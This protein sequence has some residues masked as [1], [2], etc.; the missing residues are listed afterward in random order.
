MTQEDGKR[1]CGYRAAELIEDGMQV[2][3]GTGSTVY[4]FIEKLIERVKSGLNI[5]AAFSSIRSKNQAM[6]GGIPHIENDLFTKLD[7]T[8]DG[9]DEI[10]AQFNMIKGGGGA[11]LREKILATSS[12]KMIII[13]DESKEVAKLGGAKLPIEICQFAYTATIDK[14]QNLGFN[15][16]IRVDQDRFY[17]TDGGNFIFDLNLQSPIDNVQALHNQLITISGVVETGL[18]FNLDVKLIVGKK[19][20]TLK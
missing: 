8:V 16:E 14:I 2:G 15:G 10:D 17:Q 12:T 6:E 11:L 5:T 1:A 4:F 7:V 20:G 13:V 3:I 18:F 9:A 19:D